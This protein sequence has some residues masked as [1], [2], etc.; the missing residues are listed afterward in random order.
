VLNAQKRV[1]LYRLA[2]LTGHAPEDFRAR[3]SPA[4]RS[5]CSRT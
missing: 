4:N 1:A 3:S 5:H 2:V